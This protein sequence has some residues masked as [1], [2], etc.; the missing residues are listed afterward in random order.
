VTAS[1]LLENRKWLENSHVPVYA[2][3]AKTGDQFQVNAVTIQ[4]VAG[5]TE[6]QRNP[7]E[8]VLP[9][10]WT[11]GP[12]V[13]GPTVLTNDEDSFFVRWNQLMAMTPTQRVQ[14]LSAGRQDFEKRAA[15]TASLAE[16]AKMIGDITGLTFL[17]N[18]ASMNLDKARLTADDQ[19]LVEETVAIVDSVVSMIEES[20]LA[21]T[22]FQSLRSM[23]NGHTLDHITRVFSTMVSFLVHYN[24]CHT[25]GLDQKIRQVFPKYYKEDYRHLVPGI[26][27]SLAT[28][29]NLVRLPHLSAD[30]VRMY[31]LGALMH[32]IGKILDLSYFENDAPYDRARIKQHPVV[33]SGLFQ[34]TYGARFEEARCIIG[35]HHNYLYHADGYGLSRWERTRSPRPVSQVVC[36]VADKLETFT[37]G[38]A[39]S[40]LPVE[41]CAIIDVYDALTDPSRKYKKVLT[42]AQAVGLMKEQF[43]ALHKID[44]ILFD[45]FIDFL[46]EMGVELPEDVGLQALY[47]RKKGVSS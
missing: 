36:C 19:K 44:P 41:I 46:K 7:R 38:Q 29:D 22:L 1:Y 37:S 13:K 28:S 43:Q 4:E 10:Q 21:S 16:R 45:L 31:A 18:R 8:Y 39:L 17:V 47:D 9:R 12:L 32:D 25:K 40:F 20:E 15:S 2:V 23:S 34:R 26:G 35:D 3:K 11:T 6:D 27:E 14:E 33:G 5:L 30:R 24:H 42:P